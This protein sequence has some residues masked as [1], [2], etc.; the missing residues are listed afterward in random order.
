LALQSEHYESGRW[1]SS[2]WGNGS[3]SAF[4]FAVFLQNEQLAK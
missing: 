4:A 3:M 1:A 2:V